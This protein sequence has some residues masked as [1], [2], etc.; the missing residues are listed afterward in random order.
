L[1]GAELGVEGCRCYDWR[2]LWYL[3]IWVGSFH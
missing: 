2:P 3:W 1:L